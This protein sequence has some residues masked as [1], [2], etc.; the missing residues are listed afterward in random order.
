MDWSP[1]WRY[2]AAFQMLSVLSRNP[3]QCRHLVSRIA[4]WYCLRRYNAVSSSAAKSAPYRRACVH[5]FRADVYVSR[6]A[7]NSGVHQ[8]L[9][10]EDGRAT[11]T[12][13]RIAEL[14]LPVKHPAVASS[15]ER[16][17]ISMISVS[18]SLNSLLMSAHGASRNEKRVVGGSVGCASDWKFVSIARWS[19]PCSTGWMRHRVTRLLRSVDAR[20]RSMVD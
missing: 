2:R 16:S 8:R 3:L 7:V 20:T 19:D 18:R 6:N 14:I 12:S 15:S 10:Y 9:P 11:G 17:V 4:R 13:L 1:G 5:R